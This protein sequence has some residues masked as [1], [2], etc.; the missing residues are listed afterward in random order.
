MMDETLALKAEAAGYDAGKAA[1]SWVIDGNTTP[2]TARRFLQGLRDCDPEIYDSLPSAPLSGEWADGLLPRDVLGWY[3]L[4]DEEEHY[5][6]LD[7]FEDG[8]HRGVETE[9]I[10]S[11]EAIADE[12]A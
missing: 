5:Y 7:A 11:A 3:D 10:R 2:E 9:V 1:G 6:I 8:Y 12:E 4:P